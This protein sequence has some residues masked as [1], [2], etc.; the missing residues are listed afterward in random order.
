MERMSIGRLGE[1]LNTLA[2]AMDKKPV[3]VKAMEVWFDS[4]KEFETE[5]ILNLLGSWAKHHPRFPVP[6]DVW[7][8]ANEIS[9][10]DREQRAERKKAEIDR[11]YKTLGTTENGRRALKM[12]I[13]AIGK[14]SPPIVHWRKVLATPGLPK[15]TYI[16]AEHC[17]DKIDPARRKQEEAA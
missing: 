17:L 8:A 4:L 16:F 3:S 13:A 11:S 6:A 15:D 1:K 2:E 12:V 5:M 14:T 9:S 10:E 7:K